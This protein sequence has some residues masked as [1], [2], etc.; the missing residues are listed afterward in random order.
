LRTIA[1]ATW[2]M[3]RPTGE[4]AGWYGGD[5]ARCSRH[6]D[7]RQTQRPAPRPTPRG[8]L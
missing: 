4:V 6:R 1:G 2:R 3:W 5:R 8:A 7:E